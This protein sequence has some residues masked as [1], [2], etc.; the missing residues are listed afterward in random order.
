MQLKEALIENSQNTL[1]KRSIFLIILQYAVSSTQRSSR[2]FQI[3][4]STL[5]IVCCFVSLMF[6]V[7]QYDQLLTL[8]VIETTQGDY[9]ITWTPENGNT[10]NDPTLIEYD[11][12]QTISSQFSFAI[13]KLLQNVR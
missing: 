5:F 7:K 8:R 2:T 12:Y 11:S 3:G 10:Y 6:K 4:L 9:D 13:Y 1:P